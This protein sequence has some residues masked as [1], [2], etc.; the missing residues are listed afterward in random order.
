MYR[1]LIITP[2]VTANIEQPTYLFSNKEPK[3]VIVTIKNQT[4]NQKGSIKIETP[5]GWKSDYINTYTLNS[6]SDELKIKVRITPL[7]SPQNGNLKVILND[8]QATAINT[9]QYDHI[10]TQVWFPESKAQLVFVDIKKKGTKLGYLLGAGDV[11]PD[12]LRNIGYQVDIL[13]ESDLSSENLKQYDAILTGIR[14]FNINERSPFMAPKLLKYVEDGG[15]L[16]VQYNTRH[17][18]KTQNFGPF[19]ITLSRDRV[20]EEN[21]VVT[22]L[23]PKHPILNSPNKITKEDFNNWVQERGLY[24][25]NEWDAK[26]DAILSWHDKGEEARNGS[27]LVT[28]YGKG[29]YV[30]SGISFFRELPAG[31]PGAYRLLVNL[32]ELGE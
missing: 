20:T 30:Y 9:I 28:K 24:F 27:L 17:R 29:N 18:M 12:A 32:I 11:V 4:F 23:K 31:V 22:F 19:P 16:I 5:K 2:K 7:Q 10:P 8:T 15:N 13:E 6:K 3:D 25:P 26:Y 1:P 14:F 21:A